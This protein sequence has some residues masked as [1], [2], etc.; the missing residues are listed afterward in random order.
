MLL[1][2]KHDSV[3][4]CAVLPFLGSSTSRRMTTIVLLKTH[5]LLVTAVAGVTWSEVQGWGGI[6]PQRLSRQRIFGKYCCC[7]YCQQG[8]KRRHPIFT[9][10]I[11]F[12]GPFMVDGSI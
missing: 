3:L 4:L 5:I 12:F 8:N 10:N 11:S 2:P 1:L 7:Y 9:T 6:E